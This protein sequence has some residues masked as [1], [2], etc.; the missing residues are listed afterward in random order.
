MEVGR[1]SDRPGLSRTE[2]SVGCHHCC[3]A[4]LPADF[5][6]D[7][8]RAAACGLA[9]TPDSKG[10][11]LFILHVLAQSMAIF[12][13]C[14]SAV[15]ALVCRYFPC[16][17]AAANVWCDTSTRLDAVRAGCTHTDQHRVCDAVSDLS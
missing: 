4:C 13:A 14:S 15:R 17:P 11:F 10:A 7:M 8:V 3:G 6:G 2:L 1:R 9:S 12:D 5:D 16:H